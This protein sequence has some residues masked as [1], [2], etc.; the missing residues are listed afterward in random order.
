[1]DFL[2]YFQLCYCIDY[3]SVSTVEGNHSIS[4]YTPLF[5]IL[6]KSNPDDEKSPF[7]YL[8]IELHFVHKLWNII[9]SYLNTLCL[10]SPPSPSTFICPFIWFPYSQNMVFLLGIKSN[11]NVPY[12]LLILSSNSRTLS[13]YFP[14]PLRITLGN[15]SF[16][17]GCVF[18]M[19]IFWDG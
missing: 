4:I 2:R 19:R 17:E 9:D 7:L 6:F 1:M 11:P 15:T 16:Y 13:S 18:F 8:T 10:F 5:C 14:K 12:I 3:F